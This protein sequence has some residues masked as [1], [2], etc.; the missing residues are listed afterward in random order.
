MVSRAP[1]RWRGLLLRL[2]RGRSLLCCWI[3]VVWRGRDFQG[4]N[5]LFLLY[6]FLDILLCL[7]RSVEHS[8]HF[9]IFYFLD[10]LLLC[11]LIEGFL[12]F[13]RHKGVVDVFFQLSVILEL[14]M[15]LVLLVLSNILQSE[16]DVLLQIF[17]FNLLP[18]IPIFSDC[19]QSEFKLI[20]SELSVLSHGV[21][22]HNIGDFDRLKRLGSNFFPLFFL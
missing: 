22:A 16:I 11:L 20:I 9:R 6:V 5:F 17:L 21:E 12:S 19:S 4:R 10:G 15:F 8:N 18:F 3:R 2:S 14:K 1:W 7:L 13:F